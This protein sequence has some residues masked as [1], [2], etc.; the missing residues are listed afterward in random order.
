MTYFCLELLCFTFLLH[1]I[2]VNLRPGSIYFN[3]F[4][5]PGR[6]KS[7]FSFC[8]VYSRSACIK[9]KR[10]LMYF[11]R[12][13]NTSVNPFSFCSLTLS[14]Q[15]GRSFWTFLWKISDSYQWLVRLLETRMN[16]SSMN[17]I[18]Y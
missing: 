1:C 2:T 17:T 18:V 11:F 5:D 10:A 14:Y 12:R 8:W 7:K 6:M 3:I 13:F 4:I 16:Q 15:F 9:N